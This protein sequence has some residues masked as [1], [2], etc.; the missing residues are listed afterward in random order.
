MAAADQFCYVY[1][2]LPGTVEPVPCASLRVKNVAAGVFE[3]TFTYGKR[4]LER[5]NVI[6]LDQY[7]LPLRT[8]PIKFTKL[9]V[10]NP[11]H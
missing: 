2:Q 5:T 9:K 8:K 11:D 7:H 4:Y 3:G 6:A 1:I 10:S